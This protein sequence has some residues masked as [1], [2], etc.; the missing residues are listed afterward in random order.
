M[1]DTKTGKISIA[2]DDPSASEVYW[3]GDGDSIAYLK[4]SSSIMGGTDLWISHGTSRNDS[5]D[6]YKILLSIY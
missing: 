3:L 1:L 5:Y 6:S 4:P 2:L